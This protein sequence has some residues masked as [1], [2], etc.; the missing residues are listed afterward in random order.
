MLGDGPLRCLVL[1]DIDGTLVDS[2]RL[3]RASFIEAFEVVTGSPPPKQVS[4]AGRTDLEIARDMLGAAGI[5]ATDELLESFGE[6]LRVAFA[7]RADLLR[8]RGRAYPGAG[9]AIARLDREPGVLQSLLTGNI[10][11]NAEVKLGTFG[12]DRHLDFEVGA[13]GSDHHMRG[14]LVAI[15]RR[16]A[17]RKYGMKIAPS[18]VVLIGDTP[19][20]VAAAREGRASAVG[21]ATGPFDEAA[22]REAGAD[23]VLPDL[24]D[25]D[26][27]VAAILA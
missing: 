9:E 2:V 16:K 14:E 15:A 7:A 21:V 12:L 17:E 11:P 8:E 25:V 13:Y 22:L 6:A 23:A 26:A 5:T 27:V 24:T 18:Q 4:L 19:L 1:W 3:G 10:E 20:D